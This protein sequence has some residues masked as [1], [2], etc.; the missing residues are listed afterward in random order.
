MTLVISNKQYIRGNINH[1]LK[2]FKASCTYLVYCFA[3]VLFMLCLLTECPHP[4]RD[5]STYKTVTGYKHGATVTYYC[6]TGYADLVGDATRTC[7]LGEWSGMAPKCSMKNNGNE[8]YCHMHV[9]NVLSKFVLI[10][11]N[12]RMQQIVN[13][14]LHMLIIEMTVPTTRCVNCRMIKVYI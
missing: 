13:W 1:Y 4:V 6:K 5:P 8:L 10:W 14:R 12:P 11:T 2:C 3:V 9:L 7:H